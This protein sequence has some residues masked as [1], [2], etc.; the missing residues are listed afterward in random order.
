MKV[1]SRSV[2]GRLQKKSEAPG[3][4]ALIQGC[5]SPSLQ[6]LLPARLVLGRQRRSGSSEGEIVFMKKRAEK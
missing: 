3:D 6:V 1:E 4:A 2:L 5:P